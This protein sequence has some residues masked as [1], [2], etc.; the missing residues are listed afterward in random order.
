MYATGFKKGE[1]PN[2]KALTLSRAKRAWDL[3]VS[4]PHEPRR[5][6]DRARAEHLVLA[7]NLVLSPCVVGKNGPALR[8]AMRRAPR[9]HAPRPATHSAPCTPRPPAL[10]GLGAGSIMER[11]FAT[12]DASGAIEAIRRKVGGLPAAGGFCSQAGRG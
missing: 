12:S 5:G 7:P 9:P 11:T 1:A 2:S 3:V 6:K 8:A 4:R 10:V